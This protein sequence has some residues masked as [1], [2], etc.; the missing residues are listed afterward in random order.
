[1]GSIEEKVEEHFKK[2]LDDYNIRHYGKTEEINPSITK[3]LKE[4][5]SKSGGTGNNYPD[6]QILLGNNHARY[7]PV[8]IEAKGQKGKLEKLTKD[9]EIE[10]V[11]YYSIDVK[12]KSG[13]IKHKIGEANYSSITN[14]A[15][16]GAVHYAN[17]ILDSN[18]YNEVIA[19]GINGTELNVDGSVK[20]AECKAYYISNKNNRL[21]KHII[22]LD[23]DLSLLK[24]SNANKLCGILD[25]L[26]LS[27]KEIEQLTLKAEITLEQRIKSIHQSLYESDKLK[28]ALS[29]NEKLYLFCGLIMA[30]LKTQDLAPLTLSD[31]KGNNDS[32]D[33]DGTVIT[34]RIKGFLNKKKLFA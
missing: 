19:I 4:S 34:K 9:G 5:V 29:T 10:R 26:T 8:M 33:N 18:C 14:Y 7:I 16:N 32:D 12:D 28:T 23:N 30:S 11:V 27:E 24:L 2:I 3:A 22:E 17:A 13:N 20:D 25:K 6:I 21:P 31:F 1:M 15:V